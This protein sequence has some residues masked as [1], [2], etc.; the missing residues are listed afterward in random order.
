M[1][2]QL[3]LNVRDK[4]RSILAAYV[5]MDIYTDIEYQML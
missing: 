1:A 5:L 3:H 2:C 4:V